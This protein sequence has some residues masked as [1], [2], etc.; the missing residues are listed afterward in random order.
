[1]VEYALF[2]LAH[3]RC[4]TQT[5]ELLVKRREL[6]EKKI[7]AEMQRARQLTKDKNKK[8]STSHTVELLTPWH[9][10]ALGR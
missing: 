10:D 9:V 3:K 7:D 1:M 5:E 6:L 2:P 4:P 8:G